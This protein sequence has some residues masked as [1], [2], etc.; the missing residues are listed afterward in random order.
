M[1]EGKHTGIRTSY[2]LNESAE[3]FEELLRKHNE[4]VSRRDI[5]A[6]LSRNDKIPDTNGM[7]DEDK[8]TVRSVDG[9]RDLGLCSFRSEMRIRIYYDTIKQLEEQI[10]GSIQ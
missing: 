1:R 6:D 2:V 8:K 5:L 9:A 10:K 4:L 7:N 3:A